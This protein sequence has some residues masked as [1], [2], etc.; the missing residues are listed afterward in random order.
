M[1]YQRVLLWRDIRGRAAH[2]GLQKSARKLVFT[3]RLWRQW[4]RARDA[5]HP[6]VVHL[7][8]GITI[9]RVY[10][11]ARYGAGVKHGRLPAPR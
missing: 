3:P 4:L 7:R 8:N 11:E 9:M 5:N 6:H 10:L 1:H 2:P